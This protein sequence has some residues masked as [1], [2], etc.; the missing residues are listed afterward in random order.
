MKS[1]ITRIVKYNTG[2]LTRVKERHINNNQGSVWP[3]WKSVKD[4]GIRMYL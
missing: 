1:H 4:P 3:N 2:T